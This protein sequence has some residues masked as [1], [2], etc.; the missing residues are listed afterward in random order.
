MAWLDANPPDVPQFRCPRR[1][2]PSGVVAVHT[3]ESIMD[4]VG[5]DTG[6]E[7]VARFIQHR[8]SPG[9][10]HE[11]CDSDSSVNLVRWDCEAFHDG[12]GTNRHSFGLSF[13]CSYLDWAKMTTERRAAFVERGAQRAEAYAR[14]VYAEHGI[15]V[16]PRRIS[17]E[18]ARAMVP[19]F[20]S[21]AQLD[22]DRRKD[23]GDADG[24]FPWTAFLA[25][26]AQLMGYVPPTPPTPGDPDMAP[27]PYA[28]WQ[29]SGS[30]RVYQVAADA[31][32]ARHVSSAA[33]LRFGRAL[34]RLGGHDDSIHV[35]NV[36]D[37]AHD[38]MEAWLRDVLADAGVPTA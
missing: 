13:A 25:R 4:T 35:V 27:A 7:A 32:A 12:T 15:V 16:P 20:V 9:S 2:R 18:Q 17:T 24:Q 14:W 8:D 29:L 6:A 19:G 23:P 38:D 26:F 34:L 37:A 1:D 30:P 11:L 5:P 36:G 31:I 33:A 3:A 28:F 22:P 10:Y 21:H